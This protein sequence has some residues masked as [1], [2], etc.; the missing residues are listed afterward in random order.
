LTQWKL[1]KIHKQVSASQ[2]LSEIVEKNTGV[3][4]FSQR[5]L[6]TKLGWPVSYIPDVIKGRKA[7]SVA[8]ALELAKYFDTTTIDTER[9]ILLAIQSQ[10]LGQTDVVTKVIE[11]KV[12]KTKK[13]TEEFSLLRFNIFLVFEAVRFLRGKA[14]HDAILAVLSNTTLDSAGVERAVHLLIEKGFIEKKQRTYRALKSDLASDDVGSKQEWIRLHNEFSQN[15]Q[16][17]SLNLPAPWSVFS[18]VLQID[19]DRIPYIK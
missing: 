13:A 14:T 8:R 2:L 9:I 10:N 17:V 11:A 4:G 12:P 18:A 3:R 16:K 15:F 5:L 1:P 6:S 19:A 7:L